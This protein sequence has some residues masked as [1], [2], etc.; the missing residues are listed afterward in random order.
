MPATAHTLLIVVTMPRMLTPEYLVHRKVSFKEYQNW[1]FSLSISNISYEIGK[2]FY[3]FQDSLKWAKDNAYI[4][5]ESTESTLRSQPSI[6][7]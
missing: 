2:R 1:S 4:A 3:R 5:L 7:L 6:T